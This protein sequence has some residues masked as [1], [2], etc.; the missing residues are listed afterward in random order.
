VLGDVILAVGNV[1]TVM[2]VAAEVAE[3]F[4]LLTATL[5]DSAVV[6]V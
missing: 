4:V 6:A 2:F 5:Y 3:Q 1:F